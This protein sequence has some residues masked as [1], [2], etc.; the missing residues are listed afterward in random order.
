M[1]RL[2]K[3]GEGD[4]NLDK[5]KKRVLAHLLNT[6]CLKLNQPTYDRENKPLNNIIFH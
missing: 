2:G 6:T 3:V 5:F 1:V 4:K